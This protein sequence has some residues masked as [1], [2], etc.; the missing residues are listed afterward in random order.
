[1]SLFTG[2]QRKLK[3][4]SKVAVLAAA[5]F[6]LGKLAL[7]HV[8]VSG[9]E[10]AV[11]WPP[12][13]VA[14][15]ALLIGGI[16]LWP[17]LTLGTAFLS[18]G[19]AALPQ[20]PISM[21]GGTLEAVVGAYLLKHVLGFRN[22]LDRLYDV[23]ALAGVAIVACVVGST[24]GITSFYTAGRIPAE[25]VGIEWLKFW[26]GDT[27]GILTVAPFLVV[28]A[29]G[30]RLRGRLGEGVLVGLALLLVSE[31][32][33]GGLLGPET[34]LSALGGF[35]PFLVWTALRFGAHGASLAVLGVSTLGVWGTTRGYGPFVAGTFDHRMIVLWTFL[36]VVVLTTM[37]LAAVTEERRRT[38]RA[39]RES[40]ARFRGLVE[41]A[42]DIIYALTT[43]GVFSYVSP[44]WARFLGHELAEVHGKSFESFLHPDDLE[45][46]REV[47]RAVVGGGAER[48]DIE[49]RVKHKD[50]G[51]RWYS[52]DLSALKSEGG[53]LLR[54]IGIAHDISEVKKAL[55]DLE[56][57]NQNLRQTQAQLVQSEKMAA[58]GMLV[59]G[60][61][62]EINTPV[63]AIHSMNDTLKGAVE[64]LRQ[65]LEGESPEVQAG[66][67]RALGVIG[68]ATRVIDTG[69]QRVS[70]IVRRLRSFARLDEAELKT[71]D[72][73]EGLDDT[74]S[75]VYHQIKHD[76]EL[77]K[78]Y[79]E[80]P[81]VACYP[82]RLN[83]VFLNLLVNA[84]QS[85]EDKGEISVTTFEEDGKVHVAIKDTGRGIP[86][87]KMEKI[88]DP[89]F[90]TKGVGV[91]TGLGLS[92]CYKIMQDHHG[93]IRVESEVG[94]G[95]I[96]T[97]VFPTDLDKVLGLT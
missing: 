96:F 48:S 94:K 67:S 72:I 53:R 57:A 8:L 93:E 27:M 38:R 25:E 47:F 35:F 66:A 30:P 16:R 1:M 23:A 41:N 15:A 75:L 55:G 29:T 13:G 21:A 76:I 49:Y 80:I 18:F 46:C 10:V 52:T 51:W 61:A 19:S 37:L 45:R 34:A 71:V 88:F 77:T 6:A 11:V 65:T 32:V 64:K 7:S 86:K 14:I 5:Y 59:A 89:G 69:A 73:H 39:L 97:V 85:I 79:G 62:H 43:D 60:I 81:P 2:L 95:S 20:V 68:D 87:D 90:T 74:L 36:S 9:W 12:S 70:S 28:W 92:I 3:Y 84:Q 40:E 33:F 31:L 58:L 91:G 22:S 63:G 50:G 82:D 24:I 78:H 54:L 42:N 26:L 83:Q 56:R 4:L 44:N 17:G